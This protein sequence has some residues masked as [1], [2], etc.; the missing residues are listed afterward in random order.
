MNMF[1]PLNYSATTMNLWHS[2]IDSISDLVIE[3]SAATDMD[4]DPGEVQ[5]TSRKLELLF[6]QPVMFWPSY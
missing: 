5:L 2:Y 3:L 4:W 1:K 6:A